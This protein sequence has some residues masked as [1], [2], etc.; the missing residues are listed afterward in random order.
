MIACYTIQAILVTI[1]VSILL[2]TRFPPSR[3]NPNPPSRSAP[4]AKFLHRTRESAQESLREFLDASLIFSLAMVLAS[5]VSSSLTLFAVRDQSAT[6]PDPYALARTSLQVPLQSS[7]LFST[8][9]ALFTLFPAIAL[10][11]SAPASLRR[12]KWRTFLWALLG[13]L[14][15]AMFALSRVAADQALAF[16]S[17]TQNPTWRD[18]DGQMT[19]EYYCLERSYSASVK[20]SILIFFVAACASGV[21]YFLMLP[22]WALHTVQDTPIAQKLR[23]AWSVV[24]AVLATLT[25]WAAFA[26]FYFFRQRIGERSGGT[27]KDH[28]WTFGQVVAIS[29]FAPVVIQFAM[30]WGKGAERALTGSMSVRYRAERVGGGPGEKVTYRSLE[31]EGGDDS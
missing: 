5:I 1:Y 30:V 23:D 21:I 7:V 25:M 4:L 12:K 8:F 19:F 10:H 13:A 28:A 18:P 27:N 29:T 15:L 24:A 16:M 26:T 20:L 17:T 22:V 9:A 11:S 31:A 14:T 3:P 6:V 2:S